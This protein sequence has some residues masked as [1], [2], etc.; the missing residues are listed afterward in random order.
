MCL[1]L[2]TV[3]LEKVKISCLKKEKFYI[4]REDALKFTGCIDLNGNGL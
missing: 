3:D 4:G 2:I 1:N